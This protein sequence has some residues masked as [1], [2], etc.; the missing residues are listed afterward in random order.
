MG[1]TFPVVSNQYSKQGPYPYPD[2]S[3]VTL[4]YSVIFAAPFGAVLTNNLIYQ[5]YGRCKAG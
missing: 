1:N 4:P 5:Q 3:F 2:L